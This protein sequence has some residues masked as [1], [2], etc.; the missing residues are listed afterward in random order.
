M[1]SI[2]KVVV[3]VVALVMMSPS[4]W[5]GLSS[6]STSDAGSTC[7]GGGSTDGDCL[8]S[9]SV[10]TN[11]STTYKTR[12]AWN[13]N[14]DTTVFSTH[15]T[16]GNA[17]HNASFIATAPG[18]YRLDITENRVGDMGV[19]NDASGCSGSA[20]TSGVTGSS[21]ITLNSGNLNL[22]DPGVINTTGTTQDTPFN[23]TT[24]GTIFR[25]SNGV[26]QSHTLT[27]TWNGSVRS[28]S[29]EAEV[30]EGEGSGST[31]G[32]G[33][34]GYPGSPSRT[35]ASDGNFVTVQFT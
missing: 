2:T 11:N 16:S 20:D 8:H 14:A 9:T 31:S 17:Q 13:I 28:N 21:N 32:C 19:A 4:A 6:S 12:Y 23:Q 22:P 35:Q 10:I 27:F 3:A 30:R 1:K 25:V 5:A 26:G 29:C 33:S 7:S 18:G 24:T 34:C 15:D